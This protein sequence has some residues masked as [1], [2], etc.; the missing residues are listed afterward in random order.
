M[1]GLDA[2]SLGRAKSYRVTA[3]RGYGNAINVYAAK[4]FIEAFYG[5]I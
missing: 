5:S 1:A 3:L 4:A 2:A